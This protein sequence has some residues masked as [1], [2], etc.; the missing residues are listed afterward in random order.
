VG[1]SPA[2]RE[3]RDTGIVET[4]QIAAAS[5]RRDR[6]EFTSGGSVM[7]DLYGEVSARIPDLWINYFN[8]SYAIVTDD[9]SSLNSRHGSILRPFAMRAMLL[10]EILR[11]EVGHILGN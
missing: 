3:P 11:S 10:I 2:D 9:Q 6:A 4:L 8:P 1:S 5:Q 7:R